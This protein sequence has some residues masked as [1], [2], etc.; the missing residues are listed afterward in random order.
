MKKANNYKFEGF[1]DIT[2]Y[3]TVNDADKFI[4][5]V[6]NA[7]DAEEHGRYLVPDGSRIMHAVVKIGDSFIE[8]SDG[9]EQFP[10]MPTALHLYVPDVDAVYQKALNAGATSK[11]GPKDQF[12][13]DRECYVKDP[14][15]NNWFIATHQKDVSEEDLKEH[16]TTQD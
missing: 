14:F 15:G 2:P 7:F 12:Y 3:V 11:T 9:S 5:F 13:G 10:A 16:V 4:E 8:L 1:H 6:K